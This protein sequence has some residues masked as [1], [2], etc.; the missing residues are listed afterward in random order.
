MEPVL[1]LKKAAALDV[2]DLFWNLVQTCAFS[3]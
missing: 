3:R 2:E 1:G